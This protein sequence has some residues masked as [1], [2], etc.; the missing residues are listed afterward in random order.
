[1]NLYGNINIKVY[2]YIE[3]IYIYI[4]IYIY[5]SRYLIYNIYIYSNYNS[6]DYL[7]HLI[8]SFLHITILGVE[9]ADKLNFNLN[10][11]H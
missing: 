9:V 5:K 4:K 7:N 10:E 2:I 3:I 1:M 11:L 8:L 6:I